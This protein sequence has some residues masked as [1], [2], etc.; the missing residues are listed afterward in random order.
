MEALRLALALFLPW[1]AGAAWLAAL[2]RRG[3]RRTFVLHAIAYGYLLGMLELTLLA[4]LAGAFGA[5][6]SFGWIAVAQA[7]LALGG[8]A[9]FALQR[10][11]HVPDEVAAPAQARVWTGLAALFSA[12]IALRLGSLAVDVVLRPLFPWDAWTQWATKARVWSGLHALAPF[13][14]YDQ[15]LSRSV[16][17]YVDTAPHYPPGVPF[18]QAWMALAL[19]RWDDALINLPWIG[20]AIALAVGVYAQFR[21]CHVRS[22]IAAFAAYL[23]L[24]LPLLDTHVALAGYADLHVALAYALGFAALVAWERDRDPLQ[25]AY[26][27]CA[28]ALLPLLK[29]PGFAWAATLLVGALVAGF[30]R[31]GRRLVAVVI[32]T[33][34]VALVLAAALFR[35]KLVSVAGRP[36]ADVAQPLVDNLFAFDNWHLLWYVVPIVA[37]LTWRIAWRTV[38][39]STTTLVAGGAFL[40]VTLG[41]TRAANWIADYTTVNRALLHIAPAVVLFLVLLVYDWTTAESAPDL[42]AVTDLSAASDAP[43]AADLPGAPPAASAAPGP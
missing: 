3:A 27:I 30:G 31:T 8:C 16:A 1:A 34:I 13:I 12:L 28:V 32:G 9:A 21:T 18:L 4:E 41:F 2:A 35:T 10:P 38:R 42:A 26:F 14:G 22:G 39:G 25:V 20:A 5:R 29:V 7:A 40:T 11:W 23:V 15:W 17:G 37:L 6:L 33:A 43:A 19:G 36:S 24:S